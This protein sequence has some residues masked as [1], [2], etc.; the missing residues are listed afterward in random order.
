L[1]KKQWIVFTVGLVLAV[2]MFCALGRFNFIP[3]T[4]I[5]HRTTNPD[6]SV[7]V[8]E[9]I[10]RP[11]FYANKMGRALLGFFAILG[12]TVLVVRKIGRNIS[13]GD[14]YAFTHTEVTSG[15]WPPPPKTP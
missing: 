6:K 12:G 10:I 5:V 11:H 15:A 13:F 2:G 4:D 14:E 9:T 8:V 3:S 7:T 1:Q